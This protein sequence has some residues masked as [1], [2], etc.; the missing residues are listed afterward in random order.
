MRV[1]SIAHAASRPA[2]FSRTVALSSAMLLRV[3]RPVAAVAAVVAAAIDQG[4]PIVTST[5]D[6]PEGRPGPSE[7][8]AVTLVT[9]AAP[10]T[11]PTAG[12]P[13]TAEGARKATEQ[14]QGQFRFRS[15]APPSQPGDAFNPCCDA[16]YAMYQ[17]GFE[18]DESLCE[19]KGPP[20]AKIPTTP[21]SP[22]CMD[23]LDE[24][25]IEIGQLPADMFSDAK[26]MQD[27]WKGFDGEGFSSRDSVKLIGSDDF[28]LGNS[29]RESPRHT[30]MY[31]MDDTI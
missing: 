26:G 4:L 25:S 15:L 2:L 22:D 7:A 14:S 18:P 23:T 9:A 11:I 29:P 12:A 5:R 10:A 16:M 30:V 31:H 8:S 21:L 19:F 3:R 28:S 24:A 27:C 13:S 1:V 20:E 6:G 17:P